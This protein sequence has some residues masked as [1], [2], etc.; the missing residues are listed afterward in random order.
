MTLATAS[1]AHQGE[2]PI[3][4]VEFS[5]GTT[6]YR[7]STSDV[8]DTINGTF[9]EGRVLSLGTINRQ[10]SPDY[11]PVVDVTMR[12]SNAD[13]GIDA[14]F[15]DFGTF[16]PI[17]ATATIKRGFASVSLTDFQTVASVRFASVVSI[18][19]DREIT[20]RC[21]G[22]PDFGSIV[23]YPLQD[24]YDAM[25]AADGTTWP[26]I[27]DLPSGEVSVPVVLGRSPLDGRYD[28]VDVAQPGAPLN[29]GSLGGQTFSGITRIAAIS[30]TD[31]DTSRFVIRRL[32]DDGNMAPE[33]P[34]S[35]F[36]EYATQTDE[37]TWG[38]VSV[39]LGGATWYVLVFKIFYTI[40]PKDG[41][42]FRV[43]CEPMAPDRVVL[44]DW[45]VAEFIKGAA[46]SGDKFTT[47][48]AQ[49]DAAAW[50]RVN[51]HTGT[52][53]RTTV[54]ETRKVSDVI[55]DALRSGRI[56]GYVMQDGKL[57]GLWLEP[58]GGPS[59]DFSGKPLYE[60][61][62]D[63]LTV[64]AEL[65]DRG[66]FSAANA[67]TVGYAEHALSS[68]AL[69]REMWEVT[70]N[71]AKSDKTFTPQSVTIERDS[72]ITRHNDE[73]IV[74]NI[75]GPLLYQQ[76]DAVALGE[77]EVDLRKDP[78]FVLQAEFSWR[79]LQLE[80]GDIVRVNHTAIP[81]WSTERL[82][83]VYG[84]SDNLDDHAITVTLVDFDAYLRGKVC[85][86]NSESNW[87]VGSG[88]VSG[89]TCEVKNGS[90][91]IAFVATEEITGF[92]D[93]GDVFQVETASNQFQGII[94]AIDSATHKLTLSNAGGE[95]GPVN[96][97][98]TTETGIT[99]WV[100][101]RGQPNRD[102]SAGSYTALADKYGTHG[103]PDGF[104]RDDATA[105]YTYMR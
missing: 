8:H 97:T 67:I 105:A 23:A 57:G 43:S 98:Y 6:T 75:G 14:L 101:L 54:R 4:L 58:P 53:M 21:E 56:D 3:V 88:A 95:D 77:R 38:S 93:V 36:M 13:G 1:D 10:A 89:H 71:G 60:E 83:V 92:A 28:G 17:G 30:A 65:P 55:V 32:D 33:S 102:T 79:A 82:C 64:S 84:I 90:S 16:S 37:I 24:V 80:L 61:G 100:V 7:W 2:T 26:A 9:Y 70:R 19:G 47:W 42:V 20:I 49:A 44:T 78:R 73:R 15:S 39:T 72:Y 52:V 74:A 40:E 87:T 68:A 81:G 46:L 18:T 11:P 41:T 29:A 91:S 66:Q 48:A 45:R 31:F 59:P 69:L 76:G 27:S 104:F 50:S 63:F 34:G 96:T 35:P 86:F 5:D 25:T 51:N 12:I 94:T 85:Y 99:A 62:E 22:G 103:A